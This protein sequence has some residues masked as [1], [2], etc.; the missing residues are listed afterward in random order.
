MKKKHRIRKRSD[1]LRIARSGVYFKSNFILVQVGQ[2][3]SD[4]ARVGFSV[5]KK[6][7]NAV[8][9]N[10]IKRRLRAASDIL[11]KNNV[12]LLFD[13]VF[14]AKKDIVTA[15]WS[16]LLAILETAVNFLNRKATKCT[17]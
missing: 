14:I 13:Y 16:D 4:C 9:R 17:S 1:F 3:K 10:R 12:F 5:S 11:L 7:G 15:T 8:V 2:G 6:V